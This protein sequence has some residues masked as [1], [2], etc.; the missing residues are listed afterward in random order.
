[1]KKLEL[2]SNNELSATLLAG[3][4]PTRPHGVRVTPRPACARARAIVAYLEVG[5]GETPGDSDHGGR[6]WAGDA[7]GGQK[8]GNVGG[9]T[10]RDGTVGI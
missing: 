1:M 5:L 9:E 8:F 7:D 4:Q 3:Q 10:E 2:H 6:Q